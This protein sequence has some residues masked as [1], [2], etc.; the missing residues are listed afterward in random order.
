MCFIYLGSNFVN[1]V[2]SCITESKAVRAFS[3][4]SSRPA[5]LIA[6]RSKV[7][8]FDKSTPLF[9]LSPSNCFHADFNTPPR[10]P[11]SYSRVNSFKSSQSPIIYISL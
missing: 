5:L 9:L 4:L 11:A 1:S 2:K 7:K 10:K 8:A 6:I 3:L